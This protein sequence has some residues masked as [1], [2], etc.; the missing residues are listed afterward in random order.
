MS[1]FERKLKKEMEKNLRGQES[2]EPYSCPNCGTEF[3]LPGQ[4]VIFGGEAT[5]PTCGQVVSFT[6][7]AG[8]TV[9]SAIDDFRKNLERMN[10]KNRRRR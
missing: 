3:K 8:D 5:C 4:V 2:D 7:N 10:R 9:A 6:S 1:S